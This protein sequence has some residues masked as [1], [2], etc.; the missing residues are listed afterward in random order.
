MDKR[1]R[2]QKARLQ[3]LE[4]GGRLLVRNL[5]EKEGSGKTK[6]FWEQDV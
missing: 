3:S 2:D 6:V 5:N 1:K 4:M